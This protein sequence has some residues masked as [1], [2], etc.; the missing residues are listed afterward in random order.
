MIQIAQYGLILI[1]SAVLIFHI[2]VILKI[3]PYTIVWGGRLKTDKDMYKFE[4]VSILVNLIFLAIIL[5]YSDILKIDLPGIFITILLWIMAALFA[6]NTL[7]N[8]MSKNKLEQK[9]FTPMT[10]IL[11][12]FSVILALA[13]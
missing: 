8:L 9:L 4:A 13:N 5:I 3:I 7:G 6:L 10:V 1:L 11:T 12:I 2:L